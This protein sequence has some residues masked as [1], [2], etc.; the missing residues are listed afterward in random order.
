MDK[1]W[2]DKRHGHSRMTRGGPSYPLSPCSGVYMGNAYGTCGGGGPA[3][4]QSIQPWPF[5]QS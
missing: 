3:Y 1:P 4:N 5:G 2:A